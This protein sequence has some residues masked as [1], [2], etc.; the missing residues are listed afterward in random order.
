[1]ALGA[2]PRRIL[3]AVVWKTAKVTGVG[4]AAGLGAALALNRLLGSVLLEVQPGDPAALGTAITVQV[5]RRMQR[6]SVS[7]TPREP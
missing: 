2:L 4:C 6:L 1:M 7:L 3:A 5:I